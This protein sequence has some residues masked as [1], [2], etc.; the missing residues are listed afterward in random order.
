MHHATAER[1]HW[2]RLVCKGDATLS[3][4]SDSGE[5][6]ASL[7][8]VAPPARTRDR[9]A[10]VQEGA[11][12]MKTRCRS[13]SMQL[14]NRPGESWNQS[15]QWRGRGRGRGCGCGHGHGRGQQGKARRSHQASAS[16]RRTGSIGRSVAVCSE[17]NQLFPGMPNASMEAEWLDQ[18]H[19][20]AFARKTIRFHDD[21]CNQT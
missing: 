21:P 5:P 2:A 3:L 1:A 7:A 17:L 10:T 19:R 12:T 9:N 18:G 16:N 11:G 14:A 6:A 13:R 8:I 4:G 15:Q 20:V